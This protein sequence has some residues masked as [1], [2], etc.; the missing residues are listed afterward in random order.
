MEKETEY[1]PE[2][3]PELKVVYKGLEIV[4]NNTRMSESQLI[5]MLED[6]EDLP[7]AA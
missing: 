2:F 3:R 4:V 5:K 6:Y 1:Q 7:P